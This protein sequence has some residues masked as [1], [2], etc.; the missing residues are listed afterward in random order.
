MNKGYQ[1]FTLDKKSR[2]QNV[3][4]HVKFNS[5]QEAVCRTGT[6]LVYFSDRI[7]Q[8]DRRPTVT[9]AGARL[10][11]GSAPAVAPR[12]ARV[13][14][15][16]CGGAAL[17]APCRSDRLFIFECGVYKN[18][19]FIIQVLTH[20]RSSSANYKRTRIKEFLK[21]KR[22]FLNGRE[23]SISRGHCHRRQYKNVHVTIT[24]C[25]YCFII[26]YA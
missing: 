17:C 5:A 9:V 1:P 14:A 26:L 23:P 15:C 6:K 7:T 2:S 12:R 24:P 10:G 16:R 22:L 25:F 18:G 8:S 20:R 3:H 19:A 4:K 21:H 11:D 13:S